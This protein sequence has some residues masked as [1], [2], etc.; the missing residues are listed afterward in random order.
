MVGCVVPSSRATAEKLPASTIRTK[1]SIASRRSMQSSVRSDRRNDT[2]TCTAL[3]LRSRAPPRL[4][5]FGRGS[6]RRT[7]F[8]VGEDLRKF[9]SDPL[10]C[11]LD[12]PDLRTAVRTSVPSGARVGA[13]GRREYLIDELHPVLRFVPVRKNW[14]FSTRLAL[15]KLVIAADRK[16]N[17]DAT[18][19][20]S[21]TADA[22]CVGY[23]R[24]AQ[25]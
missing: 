13:L 15:Q 4:F 7:S 9:Q 5:S 20:P 14:D 6:T 16:L 25:K 8:A 21:H 17:V 1:M 3:L 22:I 23:H 19:G 2:L 12:M 10:T 11:R 18:L 24:H